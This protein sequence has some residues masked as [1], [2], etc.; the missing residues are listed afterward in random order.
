MYTVVGKKVKMMAL[1]E[2]GKIIPKVFRYG[3]RDYKV[4]EISL[5]Y[6]EREG[7]SVNYYFG[8]ET[9]DGGVMKLHY[10]DEKLTWTLNEIWTD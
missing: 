2:G 6:Q 10:N 1:F 8:V 5:A 7:R 9:D 3:G 4:R